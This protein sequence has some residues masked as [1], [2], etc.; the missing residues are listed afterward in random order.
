MHI[1]LIS[2]NRLVFALENA[3]SKMR[4]KQHILNKQALNF[5]VK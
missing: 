5:V 1:H 4:L 2:L 3:M